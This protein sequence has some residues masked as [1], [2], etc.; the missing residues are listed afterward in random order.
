MTIQVQKAI[1][2]DY[3]HVLITKNILKV[4]M[5][6]YMYVLKNGHL[7]KYLCRIPAMPN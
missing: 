3:F 4:T 7:R 1:Q 5:Y 6:K 2:N